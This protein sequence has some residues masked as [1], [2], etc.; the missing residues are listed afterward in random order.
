M[1]TSTELREALRDLTKDGLQFDGIQIS[2]A[3]WNEVIEEIIGEI[4]DQYMNGVQPS[5]CVSMIAQFLIV[6]LKKVTP[7]DDA[8]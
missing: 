8:T 1:N 2:S 6:R 3:V 7:E 4:I 5:K